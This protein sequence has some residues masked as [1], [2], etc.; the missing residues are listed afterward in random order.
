M[1]AATFQAV[2]A[3]RSVGQEIFQAREQKGTE[4]TF[5]PIDARVDFALNQIRKKA[6][7]KILRVI[8]GVA[9]AAH[10]IVKRRP[11]SLTKLCKRG[12]RKLGFGL[13]SSRCEH[14]APVR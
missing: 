7:C 12:A 11:I 2:F 10:E 5:L 1:S 3:I 6:L 8:H 13:T 14:H 4:L 9:A